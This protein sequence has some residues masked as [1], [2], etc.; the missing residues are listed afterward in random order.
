MPDWNRIIVGDAFKLPSRDPRYYLDL[1][2]IVPLF[3]SGVFLFESV[4]TW[5]VNQ[6]DLKQTGISAGLV[7]LF[8]L[9]IKDHVRVVAELM[10]SFAFLTWLHFSVHPD[11]DSL[12]VS[13][14]FALGLV[15]TVVLGTAFRIF[16]LKIPVDLSYYNRD[17]RTTALGIVLVLGLLFGLGFVGIYLAYR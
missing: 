2:L 14:L 13:L 12:K 7:C 6:W 5:H 16:V 1:V 10:Y 3:F 17:R 4:H 11:L 9:L 8:I 15:L